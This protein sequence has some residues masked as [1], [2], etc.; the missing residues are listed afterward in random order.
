M[1]STTKTACHE[2]SNP[3]TTSLP[4]I[5]MHTQ[6]GFRQAKQNAQEK[7][8]SYIFYA[9]HSFHQ[10]KL[11]RNAQPEAT[12]YHVVNTNVHYQQKLEQAL[13]NILHTNFQCVISLTS[14]T[15]FLINTQIA[16]HTLHCSQSR[17]LK[18]FENT[19]LPY[20][21]N[22]FLT[23]TMNAHANVFFLQTAS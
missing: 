19:S 12:K 16:S 5:I 22:L 9:K 3:Q 1:H 13:H 23:S 18:V 2:Q 4:L 17:N 7:M 11:Y 21:Q 14:Q 15:P 20:S 6:F 8:Y 10:Q